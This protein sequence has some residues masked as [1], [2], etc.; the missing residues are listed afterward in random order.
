M[1]CNHTQPHLE[2]QQFGRLLVVEEA[3]RDHRN[4]V[5]WRCVCSCGNEKLVISTHLLRGV[6]RSCGCLHRENLA[7][8]NK[9]RTLP[10]GLTAFNVLY[11]RYKKTAEKRKL[12]FDLTEEDFSFITKMNCSYCGAEPG[13]ITKTSKSSYTYT[14][15]DRVDNGKGYNLQNVVPCC[16]L[17]NSMKRDLSASNFLEH[18]E[19]IYSRRN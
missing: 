12:V 10:E 8:I 17:C 16:G 9:A 18:I 14:G 1:G 2:G 15:I 7:A 5:L 19:R 13:Q 4:A 6:V 11:M 3:G